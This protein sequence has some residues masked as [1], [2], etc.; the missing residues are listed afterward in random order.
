MVPLARTVTRNLEEVRVMK[1]AFR[2]LSTLV[3]TI[4]SAA[5]IILEV[6][7]GKFP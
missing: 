3:L 2:R 6:A 4:S 5:V 7:G 1:I